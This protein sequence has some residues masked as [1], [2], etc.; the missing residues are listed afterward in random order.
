M[1]QT[2]W[3]ASTDPG[4][5]LAF[6]RDRQLIR[7]ERH[8]FGRLRA[9]Q[10]ADWSGPAAAD[11]KL[12]LFALAC[13]AR[14]EGLLARATVPSPPPGEEFADPREAL[15][16]AERL[17]EGGVLDGPWPGD[18]RF[19]LPV[20]VS[21][22]DHAL[23]AACYA[24]VDFFHEDRRD[25]IFTRRSTLAPRMSAFEAQRIRDST[26]VG[27]LTSYETRLAVASSVAGPPP[28]NVGPQWHEEWKKAEVAELAAHA[29]LVR[30]LFGNPFRSARALDLDRF[31]RERGSVPS[32]ASA[33]YARRDF[34][35]LP[36]LADALEDAGCTDA[37]VLGHLRGPGPHCRGCWVVDLVTAK[38]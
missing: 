22:A 11:R 10:P 14:V 27:V 33:I 18:R 29:S 15:L 8:W 9:G 3:Q 2:E 13:C 35:R 17:L 26:I 19:Y 7:S 31:A 38:S 34:D 12:W 36:I 37:E 4:L 23:S 20:A 32:V 25:A 5:M 28:A 30:C 24:A 1:T 16:L 21:A 6:L